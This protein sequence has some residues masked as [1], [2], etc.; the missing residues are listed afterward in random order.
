MLKL[1]IFDMD[2]LMFDSERIY[3]EHFFSNGKR[4][5]VHVDKQA[6]YRAIGTNECDLSSMFPGPLPAGMSRMQFYQDSIDLSTDWMCSHGVPKKPGLDD[7][8][9]YL[10]TSRIPAALATS[11]LYRRAERL[12]KCAGIFSCFDCIITG[13]DITHGK[14]DPEI[15]ILA[16]SRMHVAPQDAVVFE[17]S[18]NG[19]R[20]AINGHIPVIV[21][22]D[23]KQPEPD[24]CAN[25]YRIVSSLEEVPGILAD[26]AD[27]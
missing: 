24:V 23:L 19:A 27:L 8:L 14:P 13:D 17:D 4:L 3:V 5:H 6:L 16:C 2:G 1:A 7:L 18:S 20:A 25:A 26:S 11:T 10:K 21:C 15:F 9:A 12:L 22:P